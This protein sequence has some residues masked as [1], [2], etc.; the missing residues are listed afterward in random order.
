VIDFSQALFFSNKICGVVTAFRTV[1]DRIVVFR[2]EENS[3]RMNTCAER[4]CMPPV[5]KEVFLDAV[6]SVVRSNSQWVAPVD[7]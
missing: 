1:K 7:K 2:P 5:P 4:F 6:S 3:K